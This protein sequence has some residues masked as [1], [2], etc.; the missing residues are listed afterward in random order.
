MRLARLLR[1]REDRVHGCGA[2]SAGRVIAHNGAMRRV[3]LAATRH[4]C[5]SCSRWPRPD[6]VGDASEYV[7]MAG[8]LADMGAPRSRQPT[9]PRS[10]RRGRHRHRLRAADAPVAANC[11][12][13]TGGGTCHTCGCIRC[14]R[15][16]SCGSRGSSA[17]AT[18]GT[19]GAQRRDGRRPAL[20]CRTTWCGAVDADP[21]REPT[22]LV[23][24][25]ATGRPA[26]CVRRRRRDP[27]VAASG[28]HRAARPRDSTE[29]GPRR[30]GRGVHRRG[31]RG[32]AVATAFACVGRR[33]R[34]RRRLRESRHRRTTSGASTASRR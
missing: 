4:G 3:V 18:M 22:R 26:D 28:E 12:D 7:A 24:G 2:S 19:R 32:R 13:A 17:P 30:R 14:C 11:R 33:C 31:R 6:S 21:V 16:R 25:Q 27:A 15:S 8:R 29:P 23:A 9:S 34:G 10:R 1:C 5:W 20:A